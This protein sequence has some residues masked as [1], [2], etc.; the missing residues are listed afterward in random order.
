MAKRGPKGPRYEA[1]DHI[2][3]L[4]AHDLVVREGKSN[5]AAA[6]AV[7]DEKMAGIGTDYAKARRIHDWLI[8]IEGMPAIAVQILEGGRAVADAFA[9]LQKQLSAKH[10]N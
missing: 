9:G 1:E 3:R 5:W 2:Y 7:V 8:E 4:R 10:R 6:Q